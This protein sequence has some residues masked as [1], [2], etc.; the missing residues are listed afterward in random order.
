M[1][2]SV[3]EDTLERTTASFAVTRRRLLCVGFSGAVA[4]LGMAANPLLAGSSLPHVDF[5]PEYFVQNVYRS[6]L[7]TH[8]ELGFRVNGRPFTTRLRSTDGRTWRP[9]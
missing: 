4:S 2:A 6:G 1:F 5:G 8:V 9:V 7:G 3:K